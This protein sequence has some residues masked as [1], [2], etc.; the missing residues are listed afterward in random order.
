MCINSTWKGGGYSTIS[1]TSMASPHVAGA[2]ALYMSDHGTDTP[3]QV[4]S[5]LQAAGNLI[6]NNS[7][8]RDASKEK[9]LNVDALAGTTITDGAPANLVPEASFTHSCTNLTCQFA[10]TSI[11]SDGSIATRSWT[12]GHGDPSTAASPAHT[13]AAGGFY[14][15]TLTVTDNGGATDT[16]SATVTVTAPATSGIT[17]GVSGYKLKGLQK[18]DLTW[19]GATTTFVD[20]YRIGGA[21]VRVQQRQWRYRYVHRPHQQERRRFLHLQGVRSR[22]GHYLLGPGDD[23][24]LTISHRRGDFRRRRLC[25]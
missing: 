10:D 20:I 18:A 14:T 2:A 11:D 15:V 17:L 25:R 5:A 12:F 24:F 8:D 13:Y 16:A 1:G 23:Q 22:H 9:L 4:K 3:D 21:T 7:D 19:T 6:W